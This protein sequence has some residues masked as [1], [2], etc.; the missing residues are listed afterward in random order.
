MTKYNSR[1]TRSESHAYNSLEELFNDFS[2]RTPSKFIPLAKRYGFTD[3]KDIRQF[4]KEKAPHDKQVEKPIYLPIFSKTKGEYQM[5][6]MFC[7]GY[8]PFL[9][10]I[11]IN[12]RKAYAYQ[13]SNK[14]AS[15]VKAALER[16]F[17]EVPGVKAI[18]SDQDTAYLSTDVLTYLKE[19]NIQYRTT[20][21]NNHNVLGIINRF[22]RTLRDINANSG[23]TDARM[24]R[25]IKAYNNTPHSG[26]DG[27]TPNSVTDNDEDNYIKEKTDL[28]DSIKDTYQ[29]DNGD[30]VRIVLDK[31]K[32]GK[33]RTNLSMEAY[34]IDGKDGNNYIIKSSDGSVDKY[35]GYRLVKC[36]DRYKIAETIKQGKRGIIDKIIS[37]DE[38]KDAY[39]VQYDEGT[40]D[41]IPARNL[42][43]GNPLHISRMEREYWVGKNIPV[44][45]RKWI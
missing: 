34:I 42:R 37:Y 45:I 16:F 21:D 12:T 19:K 17:N 25:L 35:P 5:D 24:K 13:M 11:N 9:I 18:T 1:S 43:E 44:K 39:K 22:M 8:S 41:T 10:I 38:N 30:H 4:L 14:N 40:V 29:F 32:I 26:L 6:T 28:T 33:N 3:E 2:W 7:K 31:N 23:F 20:E 15:S 27:R 36:D